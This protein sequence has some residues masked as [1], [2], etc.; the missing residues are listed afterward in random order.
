VHISIIDVNVQQV[1]K[2][3][4]EHK[5]VPEGAE[6]NGAEVDFDDEIDLRAEDEKLI[7][8]ELE[9]VTTEP[10]EKEEATDSEQPKRRSSRSRRTRRRAPAATALFEGTFDHGE[11]GYGLW[12][13]PAIADNSIYAENWAGHRPV[14]VRVESDRIVITRSG[15]PSS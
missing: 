8:A 5:L 15:E 9:A 7:A 13:D 1:E 12:L 11:E 10:T 2:L 3:R 6:I 14:Q 4:R